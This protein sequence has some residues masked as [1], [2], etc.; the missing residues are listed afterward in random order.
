M[1]Y[2]LWLT[3]GQA[4]AF[5]AYGGSGRLENV[6]KH[7]WIKNFGWDLY[8]VWLQKNANP[9]VLAEYPPGKDSDGKKHQAIALGT[10]D[11]LR[12]GA[13]VAVPSSV[14]STVDQMS[15]DERV[16]AVRKWAGFSCS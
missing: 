5:G 13:T 3:L 7:W 1:F 12:S 16:T 14:Y 4:R 9:A 8:L 15:G 6:Y 2:S 10:G 11:S